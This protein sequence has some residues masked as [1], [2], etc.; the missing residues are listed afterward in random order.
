M[1]LL[2]QQSVPVSDNISFSRI[3]LQ[4]WGSHRLSGKGAYMEHIKLN[5]EQEEWLKKHG[6]RSHEDV[7]RDENGIFVLMYDPVALNKMR[8]VYITEHPEYL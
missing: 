6:D 8:K 7:S 5:W 1:C 2:T 4:N 3:S